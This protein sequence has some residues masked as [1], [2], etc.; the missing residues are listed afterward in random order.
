[1]VEN[2]HWTHLP[3]AA[4]FNSEIRVLCPHQNR[5]VSKVATLSGFANPFL[6][7]DKRRFAAVGGGLH[8]RAGTWRQ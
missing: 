1:V 4:K 3:L 2:M 5:Q 8:R 6:R 7:D